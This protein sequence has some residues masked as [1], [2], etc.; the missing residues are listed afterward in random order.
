MIFNENRTRDKNR[1]R[2]FDVENLFHDDSFE[3]RF[4]MKNRTRDKLATGELT[5]KLTKKIISIF[6]QIFHL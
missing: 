5:Q 1:D 6:L 2:S 3:R 4:L